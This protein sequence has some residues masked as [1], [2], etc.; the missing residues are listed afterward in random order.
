MPLA[1]GAF[2]QIRR[3]AVGIV[4]APEL[5]VVRDEGGAAQLELVPEP[6]IELLLRHVVLFELRD[7]IAVEPREGARLVGAG[8]RVQHAQKHDP[9]ADGVPHGVDDLVEHLVEGEIRVDGGRD[10]QN[11]SEPPGALAAG[12]ELLA[13]EPPH[14]LGRVRELVV[15]L[16]GRV[17]RGAESAQ[18]AAQRAAATTRFVEEEAGGGQRPGQLDRR[19]HAAPPVFA[20]RA[21]EACGGVPPSARS[22]CSVT[23]ATRQATTSASNWLP[24]ARFSSARASWSETGSR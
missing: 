23:I 9:V 15:P 21:A 8:P 12:E 14:L 19:R 22:P 11:F 3:V 2:A 20:G 10:L 7:R 1:L 4:L 5:P 17:E 24:A 6:R 16:H 18:L 13:V